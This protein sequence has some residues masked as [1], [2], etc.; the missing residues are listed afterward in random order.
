M[1]GNPLGNTGIKALASILPA[2]LTVLAIQNT[3]FGTDGLLALCKALPS[4]SQ[5]KQLDIGGNRGFD[6]PGWSALGAA[7]AQLT[8]LQ[9]LT[10]D[11]MHVGDE[12]ATALF[13]LGTE[14]R[15]SKLDSM[16][17]GGGIGDVGF[18]ALVVAL[19]RMPYLE[20]VVIGDH[21]A[22]AAAKEQVSQAADVRGIDLTLTAAARD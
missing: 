4:C 15:P 19:P 13:S 20:Q 14:E 18:A 16:F 8:N 6:A 2:T 22:T 1:G 3:D 5:L 12:G 9:E 11:E 21:V 17:L 7:L 10:C